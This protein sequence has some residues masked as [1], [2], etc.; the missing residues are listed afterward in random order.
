MFHWKKANFFFGSREN[1]LQPKKILSARLETE[2]TL[3]TFT[4]ASRVGTQLKYSR[5]QGCYPIK[6]YTCTYR[7][8]KSLF[9]VH[10]LVVVSALKVDSSNKVNTNCY[11]YLF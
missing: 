9:K 3:G 10:F 5:S 4:K 11:L 7:R 6:H 8:V 1:F 2:A